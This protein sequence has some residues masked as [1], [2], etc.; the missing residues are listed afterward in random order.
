VRKKERAFWKQ[1]ESDWDSI[2]Q[3]I[4]LSVTAEA[5]VRKTD[6]LVMPAAPEKR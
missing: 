3:S 1:A 5:K 4:E 2:Y 6:L